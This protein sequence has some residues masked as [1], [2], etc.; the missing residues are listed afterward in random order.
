[1]DVVQEIEL[2]AN[3]DH[4]LALN[5]RATALW[6]GA[7]RDVKG[8]NQERGYCR[9]RMEEGA[10]Y[11]QRSHNGREGRKYLCVIDLITE[12]PLMRVTEVVR[13]S[14][15]RGTLFFVQFKG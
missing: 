3:M 6:Q 11:N 10:V 12:W 14:G 15:L 9:I 5:R 4:R 2:Y 13:E 1:M 7:G 8:G